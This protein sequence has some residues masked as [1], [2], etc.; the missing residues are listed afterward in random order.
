MPP[1]PMLM[2]AM[3][4]RALLAFLVLATATFA[5]GISDATTSLKIAG[6]L[7]RHVTVRTIVPP[8][9]R[10]LVV[11]T[12]GFLDNHRNHQRLYQALMRKGFA[13]ATWD[14]LGHGTSYEMRGYVKSFD[15]YVV[16]LNAVRQHAA[17][18][19]PAGT[20]VY[21]LGHSLGALITL[22]AAEVAPAGIAGTAVLAPFLEPKM[23]P[24]R[25]FLNSLSAPMD[26]I[27][28]KLETP[29]G[30]TN[31]QMFRDPRILAERRTDPY[32]FPKITVHLFRQMQAGSAACFRDQSKLTGPLLFLVAGDELIVERKATD[33]FYAKLKGDKT[34]QLF[35]ESRHEMHSDHGREAVLDALT[36]WLLGQLHGR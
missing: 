33:A 2:G 19:V 18:K 9:P 6:D 1:V 26:H 3:H 27:F 13:V 11:Y 35:P 14:V 36:S 17:T 23:S 32:F 31:E 20:P 12:H 21:L 10:A 5:Q 22:R 8:R 29:H 30:V 34:Y 28:P 16:A 7:E 24:V 25:K 4:M 15:E